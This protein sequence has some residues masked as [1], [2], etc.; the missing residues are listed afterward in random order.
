MV[1][2]TGSQKPFPEGGYAK[3]GNQE[4]IVADLRLFRVLRT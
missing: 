1:D 3:A 4:G 2:V